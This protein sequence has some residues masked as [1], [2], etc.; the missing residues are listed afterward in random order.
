MANY[1]GYDEFR[2]LFDP[3]PPDDGLMRLKTS[4]RFLDLIEQWQ[5]DEHFR[6]VTEA[7]VDEALRQLKP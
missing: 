2:A 6:G 5:A 4:P 3:N 7:E 1:G